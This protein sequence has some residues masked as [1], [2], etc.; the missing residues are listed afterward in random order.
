M[1]R[2]SAVIFALSILCLSGCNSDKV[3]ETS[4]NLS[5]SQSISNTNSSKNSQSKPE[6]SIPEIPKGEP[7][8]LTCPDGTVIYTSQITKYQ[9]SARNEDGSHE[10][11]PLDTFNMETFTDVSGREVV[12]NGFAYGF[13]P[14]FTINVSEAPEKFTEIAGVQ[15]YSGEELILSI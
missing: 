1:K 5:Q 10:Q 3:P 9:G 8:F 15:M 7:T 12:C 6:S 2:V 13:I 11:F 4:D 14:R